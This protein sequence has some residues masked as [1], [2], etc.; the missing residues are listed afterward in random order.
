VSAGL[1]F[2]RLRSRPLVL[3]VVALGLMAYLYIAIFV[4]PDWTTRDVPSDQAATERGSVRTAM[5]AVLAGIAATVGAFYT[6]RSFALSRRG[7]FTERFS[8]AVDQLGQDEKVDVRLGGIYALGRLALESPEEHEPIVEILTAYVRTHARWTPAGQDQASA[9]AASDPAVG[10]SAEGVEPPDLPVDIQAA[11][12]VLTR[13]NERHERRSVVTLDL[14]QTDLRRV[15][16]SGLRAPNANLSGAELQF[17][18]LRGAQLRGANLEDAQLSRADL[19]Y[20]QLQGAR[21]VEA[22]M[23]GTSLF[24]AHLEDATLMGASLRG[25]DLRHAFLQKAYFQAADLFMARLDDAQLQDASFRDAELQDT[26][27]VRAQLQRTSFENA[28]LWA[29]WLTGAQL[30]DAILINADMRGSHLNGANLQGACLVGTRLQDADL[31]DAQ[32]QGARYGRN[33]ADGRVTEW[34]EG[35]DAERRG[36]IELRQ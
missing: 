16:A 29:A 28:Q 12:T 30:Q 35:V 32:L 6:A 4:A 25:A 2:A 13:R 26:A 3:L 36:A 9:E 19:S 10:N 31:T 1:G 11:L 18:N 24:R 14:R 20:A 5:L 7:Q 15:E 34:P 8:H 33:P 23:S 22:R 27:L 21:L 17:A